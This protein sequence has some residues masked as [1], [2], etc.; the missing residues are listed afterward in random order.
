ME[1]PAVTPGWRKS[2]HSGNGGAACVEVSNAPAGVQV[3]D[4]ANRAGAVLA[5]PAAAWRTL[6]A[7]IRS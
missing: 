5:I 4:T 7:E 6:L 1:Q 2:S 3:R